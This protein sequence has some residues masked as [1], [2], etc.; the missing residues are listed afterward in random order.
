MP[1]TKSKYTGTYWCKIDA[2]K[3]KILNSIIGYT[4]NATSKL[5]GALAED[6]CTFNELYSKINYDN[7][8]KE[9]IK[10]Y[11]DS[12]CGNLIAKKHIKY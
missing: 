10:K 11:I 5:L 2:S 8:G 9:I 3:G 12:G 6:G 4:T 7:E 1:K